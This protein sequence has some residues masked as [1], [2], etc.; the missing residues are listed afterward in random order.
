MKRTL[1]LLCLLVISITSQ[2]QSP[3]LDNQKIALSSYVAENCG[4]PVA[5]LKILESKQ[6]N[7]ITTNGFGSEINQRFILTSRVNILSEDITETTPTMYAYKLS[8]DLFI[9]DG[10]S[11]TIF[12]STQVE[13][14]G[15]GPTKDKAFLQ[16][17]KALNPQSSAIKRFVNEGKKKIIDYYNLNGS[18]IIKRAKTL[19]SRQQFDEAMWELSS[20]PESCST[21]YNQANDLIVQFYQKQINHEGAS[22]LAEARAIWN[23][24]QNREAADKA[25]T[26]LS[27]IN[28]QSSAF[29]DAQSLHNQ[30]ATRIK[31]LDAREW[32]FKLQQQKD[33]TS[34][35]KAQI[36]SA[37][38]VA[39]AWAKNRPKT[40]YRIYW[41]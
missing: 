38:D 26:I 33:Y 23:T 10:L 5:S 12:A 21:Y 24:G 32:S 35:R 17:L 6:T 1:Q 13:A 2:A 27:Q 41:W 11:G 14:K 25:G 37:R 40:V 30:I 36:N 4:V 19:A 3:E 7:I 8:F 28:P 9:G 18:A 39:V 34:I 29:K 31:S 15:V 22:M 20:I 16:A